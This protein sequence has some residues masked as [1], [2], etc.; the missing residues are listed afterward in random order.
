META[1][2]SVQGMTCNHCVQ[3]VKGSLE[4]I[5]G[6]KSV[7][8]TLEK[9]LVNVVYDPAAAKPDQFKTAIVQAGYEVAG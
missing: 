3:T 2:L 4:K 9:G 5:T 1:T 6:V 7:A 8:V